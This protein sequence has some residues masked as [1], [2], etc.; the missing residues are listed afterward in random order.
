M[1]GPENINTSVCS[2]THCMLMH[3]LYAHAHIACSCTH[4]MLMHT[5]YAQAHIVC[6]GTHCMLMHTLYAQAHIVCSGTHCMLMHTLYAQ[7]HIVCSCTHCMLM[8]TLYAQAHIAFFLFL[9]ENIRGGNYTDESN[10]YLTHSCLVSHKR[11]IGKQCRPR[12]DA[13]GCG[14]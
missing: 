3:T 4:C 9:S 11:D 10:I 13:A 14:V 2:C 6:S 8:H 5:L 12:S 7:A 1:E